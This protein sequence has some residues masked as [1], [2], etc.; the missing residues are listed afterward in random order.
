MNKSK[1]YNLIILVFV[2]LGIV[3]ITLGLYTESKNKKIDTSSNEKMDTTN[4]SDLKTNS[5]NENDNKDNNNNNNNDDDSDSD[6]QITPVTKIDDTKDWVYDAE[7]QKNVKADSYAT[8]FHT[9]YAKDIV[10]PYININSTYA[11][12]VNTEIKNIFDKVIDN[13]NEGVETER[14]YVKEC[15]Y[16]KYIN[17]DNLSVILTYG[18]GATSV[19]HPVSYTYNINLKTGKKL[20]YQEIYSM[21]GFTA[22]NIDSRVKEAITKVMTDEMSVFTPDN[23]PDGTTFDTYNNKS[24]SNY[25]K[26]V[27]NNTISYFLSENNKLNI[28]VTLNMPVDTE[29]FDTIISID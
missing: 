17:N 3:L 24:I 27:K 1:K 11:N 22:T 13:Y 12:K 29:E 10:V 8:P 9:Y 7:Y 16:K 2:L 23:Y 21:A 4:K 25:K 5:E 28:I 26:S 18:I 19:V 6:T 20:S 15:D 14:T